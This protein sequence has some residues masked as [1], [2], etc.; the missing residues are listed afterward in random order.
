MFSSRPQPSLDRTC[1]AAAAA[2][3]LREL[4]LRQGFKHYGLTEAA[5]GL[6]YALEHLLD[7]LTTRRERMGRA[8]IRYL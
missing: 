3:L 7:A 2:Q 4:D 1:T 6:E 5:D 8:I